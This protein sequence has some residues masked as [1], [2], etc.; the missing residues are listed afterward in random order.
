MWTLQSLIP[1]TQKIEIENLNWFSTFNF[2]VQV[3]T[4][5]EIKHKRATEDL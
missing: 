2:I 4:E 3:Q 5:W 1:N